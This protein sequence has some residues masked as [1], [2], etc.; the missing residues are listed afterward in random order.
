MEKNSIAFHNIDNSNIYI[1]GNTCGIISIPFIEEPFDNDYIHIF[2]D[3]PYQYINGY[4]T[5]KPIRSEATI[6]NKM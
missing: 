5:S 6:Q 1:K 4:L 3:F 2:H